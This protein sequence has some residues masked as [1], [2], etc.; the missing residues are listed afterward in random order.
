MSSRAKRGISLF[1]LTNGEIPRLTARDDNL[2]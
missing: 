2:S 1:E